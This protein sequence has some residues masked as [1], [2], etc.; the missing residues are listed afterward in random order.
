MVLKTKC[1]FVS[2][3]ELVKS[4][5]FLGPHPRGSGLLILGLD[6]RVFLIG[7]HP[8]GDSDISGVSAYKLSKIMVDTE[9]RNL[10]S[11]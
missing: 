10:N 9:I 6:P 3:G 8:G 11:A 2:A 1:D 4:A 5:R 7:Q